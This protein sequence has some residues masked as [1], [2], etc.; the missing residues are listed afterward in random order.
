MGEVLWDGRGVHSVYCVHV[1]LEVFF[2]FLRLEDAVMGRKPIFKEKQQKVR[3]LNKK[4]GER[5][6]IQGPLGNEI[7]PLFDLIEA[8][9]DAVFFKDVQGRH[10]FV[11]KA[12]ERLI[13]LG[14]EK[15]LGKSHEQLLPPDLAEKCALSDQKAIDSREP[16]RFEESMTD[17]EGKKTVLETIK[18]PFFDRRGDVAGLVGISRDITERK[19]QEED[20][21]VALAKEQEQAAK[22]E[23]IIAGIGDALTII[24]TDFKILYENKIH[25]DIIGKHIGECCYMAYQN[26]DQ[27][28]EGC[29][30]AESLKNGKIHK[31]ERTVQRENGIQHFEITASPFFSPTGK[32]AGVIEVVRDITERKRA[33]KK[34]EE[35]SEALKARTARLSELNTALKVLLEHREKDKETLEENVV[36]NVKQLV[37]PYLETLKNTQ[38]D[39]KQMTCLDIVESNLK[40]IVSPF[41]QKLSSKYSGLT[42]K[43]IQIA[44]LIKQGKTTKEIAELLNLSMRT[45]KFHRENIRAKLGLKNQR[46]NLAS[47]LLSLP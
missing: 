5:G 12:C 33:E 14:K 8:L 41:L 17:A 45:I 18:V 11:N 26:R 40:E 38:L 42:P 1:C 16:V 21:Q 35:S 32:I 6:P 25:Q 20:L 34:L 10:L 15:I 37:L 30:A 3:K 23:A 36:S 19:C 29:P 13:G 31:R 39:T 43:E 27:V 46:T 22:S 44:G 47:H 7:G 24:D 2:L 9:P 4:T 28:C